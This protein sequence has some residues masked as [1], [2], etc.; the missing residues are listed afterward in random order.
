M[1]TNDVL[2]DMCASDEDVP[3]AETVTAVVISGLVSPPPSILP[4]VAITADDGRRSNESFAL[5]DKL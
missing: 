1:N 2:D 4:A 5:V 3:A